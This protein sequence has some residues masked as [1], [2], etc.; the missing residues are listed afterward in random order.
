M[1][2]QDGA[3]IFFV[4]PKSSCKRFCANAMKVHLTNNFCCPLCRQTKVNSFRKMSLTLVNTSD[5]IV[6]RI[7]IA[8]Q[9]CVYFG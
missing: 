4:K 9:L 3:Y 5:I 7:Q 2:I 1:T 8:Y 6:L